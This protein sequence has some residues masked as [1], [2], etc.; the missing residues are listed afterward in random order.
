MY[1]FDLSLI[2]RVKVLSIC[3]AAENASNV[4]PLLRVLKYEEL[5]VDRPPRQYSVPLT[6]G[7]FI[8]I[9][10]QMQPRGSLETTAPRLKKALTTFV[11][12]ESPRWNILAI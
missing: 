3:A 6:L 4:Q 12:R 7:S 8:S 2:V 10:K 9:T 11:C 5:E 1:F